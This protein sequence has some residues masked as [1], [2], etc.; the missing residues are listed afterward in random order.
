[1]LFAP[2]A[3]AFLRH[4]RLYGVDFRAASGDEF[5]V[6][7]PGTGGLPVEIAEAMLVAA[8]VAA[9]LYGV[10]LLTGGNP[11]RDRR[12]RVRLPDAPQAVP[13]PSA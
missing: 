4:M 6:R 12:D 2:V 3:F 13:D 10:S 7:I 5:Q 8:L 1:M 11:D 9:V